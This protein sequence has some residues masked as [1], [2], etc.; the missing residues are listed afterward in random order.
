MQGLPPIPTLPLKGG[1][2][3]KPIATVPAP[4]GS[5]TIATP[6]CEGGGR[7]DAHG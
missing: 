4:R 1:G 5:Q 6:L 7:G 2:G 3:S